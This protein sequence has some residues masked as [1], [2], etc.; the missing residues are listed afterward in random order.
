L[1][2][3][4]QQCAAVNHF[5]RQIKT[6]EGCGGKTSAAAELGRQ[7]KT[8]TTSN[9]PTSHNW[10]LPTVKHRYSYRPDQPSS[11]TLGLRLPLILLEAHAERAHFRNSIGMTGYP[12]RSLIGCTAIGKCSAKTLKKTIKLNFNL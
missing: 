8:E 4:N 11:L 7:A 6:S 12:L 9:N 1:A 5:R 2:A 10:T 3:A